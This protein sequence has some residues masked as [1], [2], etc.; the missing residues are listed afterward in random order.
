MINFGQIISGY[1]EISLKGKKGDKIV[2]HHK[3]SLDS[4]GNFSPENDN[5]TLAYILNGEKEEIL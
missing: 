2:A 1:T 5:Q 4:D 3:E